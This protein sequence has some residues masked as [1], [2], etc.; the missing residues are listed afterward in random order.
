MSKL[1]PFY[2][3]NPE[4]GAPSVDV[5]AASNV[6][7]VRALHI[8]DMPANP[9]PG[10][11]VHARLYTIGDEAEMALARQG[12]SGALAYFGLCKERYDRLKAL[13]ILD[14]S[15]INEPHPQNDAEY[16]AMNA[17][18]EKWA[19]LV[20]EYGM[21]PWVW[22]WGVGWPD[23]GK[24]GIWL[25]SV[26]I[27]RRYG[28]GLIVHLYGAPA[29]FE[30]DVYSDEH[31]ALRVRR[32]IDELYEAGLERG[33]RWIV[34]GEC[35]IDGKTIDWNAG[36]Y[37]GMRPRLGWRDFSDWVYPTS[38]GPR[39]MD[40][41]LYWDQLSA[42][43]DAFEAI[44]EVR[45]L[46]PFIAH[47]RPDWETYVVNQYMLDRMAAKH[48]EAPMILLAP[49][50][51]ED[52]VWESQGFNPPL[53][54]GIDW[55]VA[56]GKPVFAAVEGKVYIAEQPSGFGKHV[57]IVTPTHKVY[58]AHLSE[59]QVTNGQY[60]SAGQ[61]IG[62]SGD[63][64]N[65]TGPHLHFEVRVLAGSPY[66]NGAIDPEPYLVWP[67]TPVPEAPDVSEWIGAAMQEFIIPL[68]AQAALEKAGASKGYLPASDEQRLVKD[69]VSYIAQMFRSSTD[70]G[71]QHGAYCVEGDWGNIHWF[72][73]KN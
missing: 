23:Y 39:V 6:P 63:T 43:D 28:G 38:T 47:P 67:T 35:G 33:D 12:A 7:A 45:W 68:N 66:L 54:Y 46:C 22:D 53:H 70:L 40:E 36:H 5:I 32:Q 57:C 41:A 61:Q 72:D 10:K 55:S 65:S 31:Y 44:P 71:K 17:F 64:G 13:G 59:W 1:I 21:R 9:F 37:A 11:E 62:L 52:V 4:P 19:T 51:P 69:G 49:L 56:V 29:V 20:G 27:A 2:Q 16:A 73:R 48:E 34:V 15:A 24:S 8:E 50:R 60:V 14:V 26:R 18:M 42:Y 3:T 58:A 30:N 25:G